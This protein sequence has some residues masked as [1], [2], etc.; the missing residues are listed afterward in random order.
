MGSSNGGFIDATKIS[1][2]TYNM[3]YN[4][5]LL[6][7]HLQNIKTLLKNGVNIKNL[8]IGI[9][10]YI[11]WKNPKDYKNSFER[12]PYRADF[13]EDFKTYMFYLFKKPDIT[14][15]YILRGYYQ[16]IF[17]DIITNPHPHTEAKIRDIEHR[18][19][20][21]I[22]KEHLKKAK[23]ILLHYDDTKYRIDEAI[24]EIS[25]LKIL[26]KKNNINLKLFFYPAFYKSYLSYN[27]NK[28]IEF[29]KKLAKVTDFFDFY[30]LNDYAYDATMWQDSMHFSYTMGLFIIKSIKE[31][32]FLVTKNNISNHLKILKEEAMRHILINQK[33][34]FKRVENNKEIVPIYQIL[35]ILTKKTIFDLKNKKNIFIK[36]NDFN[37][38]YE[39]KDIILSTRGNDPTIILNNLRTK[40]PRVFLLVRIKSNKSTFFK[41]YYK[42]NRL[43]KY[44]ENSTYMYH[45][46]KGLNRFNLVIPAEYINNS[47]RVDIVDKAGIYTIE[48]FKIIESK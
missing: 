46:K 33:K 22:W 38:R 17:S 32:K 1:P 41:L 28:I 27:Q 26:C 9:N 12:R 4:F 36:N 15:F 45:L 25:E 40:A 30:R 29:K 43:D 3:K 5:G 8:W 42:K 20:I 7:I 35:D 16:L 44:S 31:N 18:K 39:S 2:N 34:L 13:V 47:L 19:H 21:D 6:A 23:P 11:I 37:I 24:K 10:D 14:D 48:K